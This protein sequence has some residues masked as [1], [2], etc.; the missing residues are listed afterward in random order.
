MFLVDFNLGAFTKVS[1]ELLQLFLLFSLPDY[2]FDHRSHL[3]QRPSFHSILVD[4][5]ERLYFLSAN[6]RNRRNS[7]FQEL[8]DHCF[9][10]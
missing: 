4:F 3:F 8:F 1:Y 10:R 2:L 7:L 6:S 9:L 5:I